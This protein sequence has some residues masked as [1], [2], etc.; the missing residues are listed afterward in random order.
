MR[1]LCVIPAQGGSKGVPHKNKKLLGSRPLIQ[2]A[3]ETAKAA[4]RID[5]VTVSSD[6]PE[7]IEIARKCGI[8]SAVLRPPELSGDNVSLV[9]VNQ[10]L[11]EYHEQAGRVFDAVLSLQPTCPF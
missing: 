9:A 2:H 6:D 3:I 5:A 10:Y 8:E 4:R 11:L 1:I 7:I